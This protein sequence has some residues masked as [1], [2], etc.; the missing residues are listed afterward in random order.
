MI[1]SVFLYYTSRFCICTYWI[2]RLH[3]FTLSKKYSVLCFVK[4]GKLAKT[5]LQMY[6]TGLFFENVTLFELRF[7]R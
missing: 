3:F 4:G 2:L 5:H 6:M 1:S 7:R